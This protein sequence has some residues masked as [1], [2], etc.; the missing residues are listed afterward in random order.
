MDSSKQINTSMIKPVATIMR[1]TSSL[2]AYE[3]L[4]FHGL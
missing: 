4:V 2:S 3:Q 1:V